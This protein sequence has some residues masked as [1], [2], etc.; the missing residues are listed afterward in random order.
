MGCMVIA[1]LQGRSARRRIADC[2]LC[3][4]R[5]RDHD[6]AGQSSASP[7]GRSGVAPSYSFPSGRGGSF[8]PS[9]LLESAV[10]SFV[11]YSVDW[12][13]SAIKRWFKFV[14]ANM[15][16]CNID[17]SGAGLDEIRPKRSQK[18]NVHHAPA[19]VSLGHPITPRGNCHQARN[20]TGGWP[21][22]RKARLCMLISTRR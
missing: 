15:G 22:R 5:W 9:L 3:R 16:Q 7:T 13:R 10:R 11:L 12:P 14:R 19:A 21:S 20:L 17:F 4:L 18:C 2:R 6:D 1:V 8:L